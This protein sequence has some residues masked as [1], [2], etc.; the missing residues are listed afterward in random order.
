MRDWNHDGDEDYWDDV[1][2]LENIEREENEDD[3]DENYDDYSGRPSNSI[4]NRPSGQ[5]RYRSTGVPFLIRMIIALLVISIVGAFNE[6]IGL[7][8][9]IAWFIYEINN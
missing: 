9:L 2:Y 7:I 1:Y 4:Y 6:L 8:L 5:K 3:D